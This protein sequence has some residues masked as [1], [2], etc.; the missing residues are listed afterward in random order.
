MDRA[1]SPTERVSLAR[2]SGATVAMYARRLAYSAPSAP[3]PRQ[4]S[5]VA[6]AILF[7]IGWLAITLLAVENVAGDTDYSWHSLNLKVE[8]EENGAQPLSPD[9]SFDS[10]F[11]ALLLLSNGVAFVLSTLSLWLAS[12]YPTKMLNYSSACSVAASAVLCIWFFLASRF[13]F[14]A[15]MLVL[16]ATGTSVRLEMPTHLNFASMVIHLSTDLVFRH[17]SCLLFGLFATV[18]G[19]IMI[20][21]PVAVVVWSLAAIYARAIPSLSAYPLLIFALLFAL[22]TAQVVRFLIVYIL[23]GA[24]SIVVLTNSYTDTLDRPL[25]MQHVSQAVGAQFGSICLGSLLLGW[26][27]PIEIWLTFVRDKVWFLRQCSSCF[28]RLLQAINTWLFH[29]MALDDVGHGSYCVVAHR[30][31]WIVHSVGAAR[32]ILYYNVDVI[33]AMPCRLCSM[34]V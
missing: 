19:L 22:W 20:I 6:F 24:V 17:A 11:L 27:E 4:C 32:W 18:V 26:I 28:N 34:R 14:G 10:I 13:F 7:V 12:S 33:I 3:A 25:L 1:S 5:D 8:A 30:S 21:P 2:S 16:V 9:I 29:F 23:S 15:A 31:R